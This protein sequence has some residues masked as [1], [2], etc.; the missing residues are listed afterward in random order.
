MLVTERLGMRGQMEAARRKL[1]RLYH[2]QTD[3][4]ASATRVRG[5]SVPSTA[6]G[7]EVPAQPIKVLYIAGVQRS[8]STVIANAL[9]TLPRFFSAG[10]VCLLWRQA[11]TNGACG[12][13]LPVK[14]CETW[15]AVLNVDLADAAVVDNTRMDRD[16][17]S[18]RLG[19]R[20]LGMEAR[21]R[22][23]RS[24]KG[25]PLDLV[26]ARLV[27]VYSAIKDLT[28]SDVI[29][30]T[31]KSPLFGY[32]LETRPNIELY[33]LH[34]V[35]DPRGSIHSLLKPGRSRLG[36]LPS[37]LEV[38]LRCVQWCLWHIAIEQIWKRKRS[39]YLALR[40][41][42]FAD[43]PQGCVQAITSFLGAGDGVL[44]AADPAGRR[45]D[46]GVNHTVYGNPNNSYLG[47]VTI[48][49]DEEWRAKM[50]RRYRLLVAVLTWPVLRRFRA[51]D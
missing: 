25:R 48:Q 39:R 29:V 4:P 44:K 33:V 11:E 6:V 24:E 19:L 35:R 32:L 34:L 40:Y 45:I 31:S 42:D 28:G 30:D 18:K 37:V 50:K 46:M 20:L 26:G 23:S 49:R 41:E 13:G 7:L 36:V 16:L 43:S 5:M 8:G 27:R 15:K 3:D 1:C 38:V 47:T 17:N 10:E 12:C 14:E 21:R 2:R 9:G 51:V 22:I